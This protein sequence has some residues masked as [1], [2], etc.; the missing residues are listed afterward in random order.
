V[1]AYI[2]KNT[3]T[4]LGNKKVDGKTSLFFENTPL[5]V[6]HSPYLTHKDIFH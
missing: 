5:A 2:S 6:V 1:S 3:Y 4:A